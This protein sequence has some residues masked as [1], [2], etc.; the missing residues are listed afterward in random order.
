MSM[1]SLLI[2]TVFFFGLLGAAGGASAQHSHSHA[3]PNG[4]QVQA[5][6]KYE[7]ELTVKGSQVTLYVVDEAEKKVDASSMSAS[8]MV[9]A[10][11]NQQKTL[12]LRPA[13]ENK[14]AASFD[15]PVDGKFRATVTLRDAKGDLG[16]ARYNLDVK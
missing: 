2:R 15:F 5:I 16:K 10:K 8:A 9:L 1:Q 11:G 7:G 6:G 4:G 3:A 14:L 13:G 12:E